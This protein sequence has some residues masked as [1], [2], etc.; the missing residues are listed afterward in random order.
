MSK[1]AKKRIKVD[2]RAFI[3]T[4]SDPHRQQRFSDAFIRRNLI[5]RDDPSSSVPIGSP[6]KEMLTE[7]LLQRC[8]VKMSELEQY[9]YQA[10]D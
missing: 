6:I 3:V 2:I 9:E 4:L 8:G 5:F 1:F 10:D 7:I